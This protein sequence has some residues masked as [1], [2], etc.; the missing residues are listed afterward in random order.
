MHCDG[1]NYSGKIIINKTINQNIIVLMDSII[2]YLYFSY[3]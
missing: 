3:E 1:F 2:N